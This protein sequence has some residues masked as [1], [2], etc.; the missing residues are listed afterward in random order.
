MEVREYRDRDVAQIGAVHAVSRRAAYSG[1]VPTDALAR[2]TPQTQTEVWRRRLAEEIAQPWSMLVLDQPG[3]HIA[4]FVLGSAASPVAT[5]HAIHV[6]P[7]F[8][9]GG[10]GQML[11]DS[12]VTW[13]RAWNCTRALLWVLQ[14]N[15]R[16]QA[17][18]RRN[19]W[20]L[21]G[22]RASHEIGGALVP[23][24]RYRLSL[25]PTD[26]RRPE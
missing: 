4:G 23:V 7:E 24:L 2:V 8:H 21:D 15:A 9:G 25:A 1:L 16:A 6:L 17:F 22:E 19:G 10:A 18:Y 26:T 3:R 14:G 5:L 13:F 12:I 20:T 11:H